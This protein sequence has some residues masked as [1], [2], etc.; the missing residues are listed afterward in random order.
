MIKYSQKRQLLAG[1]D[2]AHRL[3][4]RISEAANI[5]IGV[6]RTGDPSR[7]YKLAV[8]DPSDPQQILRVQSR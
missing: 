1:F 8:N 4:L 6:N 3:A 5:D 7:P 2:N